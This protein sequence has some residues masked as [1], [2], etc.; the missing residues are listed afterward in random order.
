MAFNLP[1]SALTATEMIEMALHTPAIANAMQ[2]EKW[3]NETGSRWLERHAIIDQ[4][5]APFGHRAMDRASIQRGQRV[6]DVGCGCGETA[7]ELA[8]RIGHSGSVLGVAAH[9][10][11]SGAAKTSPP[12]NFLR[13]PKT[14]RTTSAIAAHIDDIVD[15]L[16][17]PI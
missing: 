9:A 6:L 12:Y 15:V 10:L 13:I 3:N 1:A 11:A 8:H 4:Q 16:E 17:K 2:R 7:F 5:I 14:L